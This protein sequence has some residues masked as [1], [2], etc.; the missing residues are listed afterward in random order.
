MSDSRWLRLG[1]LDAVLLE[2]PKQRGLPD[3]E[4]RCGLQLVV[5]ER[6]QHGDDVLALDVAVSSRLGEV[7]GL[8]LRALRE[9]DGALDGVLELAYVPAPRLAAQVV[10]G[11]RSEARDVTPVT[12]GPAL[13][14]RAREQHDVV[15]A[16]A[17]R[18][19]PELDDAQ[20]IVEVLAERARLHVGV[21]RPIGGSDDA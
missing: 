15:S 20:P 13:E 17:Q 9:Q 5:P 6:M 2:L 21:E 8:D 4:R 11:V 7:F 12:A 16:V 10:R 18:R 14:E 19:H 1:A 3:A